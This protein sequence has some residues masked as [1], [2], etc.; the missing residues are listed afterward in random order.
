MDEELNPLVE[1]ETTENVEESTEKTPEV[2]EEVKEEPAPSEEK[3]K[4]RFVTDEELNDIVDRRVSRRMKKLEKDQGI[5]KDTENV[6]KI[7]LGVNDIKEANKKLR[8]YY[9]GEG[10]E[11]PKEYEPEMTDRE[12]QA[13][14]NAD[15]EDIIEEGEEAMTN[16][17]NKLAERGY[18]NLSKREKILFTRLASTLESNKNR[19]ELLR[20]GA[21]EDLINSDDFKEFA[22]QFNS[23]TPM[24]KIL[25]LYNASNDTDVKFDNPGSMKNQ[26]KSSTD[27][28][29]YTDE[30]IN[31]LTDEQ[32]D[33]P[34]I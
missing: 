6:L 10:Y 14:A 12:I 4:G 18:E 25:G 1:E 24:E 26:D 30:E 34:K 5:Y 8:E 19:R 22:A 33:D 23:R 32:L 3:P 29:Y 9:S 16:E 2:A 13:L 20:L 21:S 11:M 15:A 7:G 27:K 17:A 28:E 31:Q